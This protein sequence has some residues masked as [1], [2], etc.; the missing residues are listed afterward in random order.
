MRARRITAAFAAALTLMACG[1]GT[2]SSATPEVASAVPATTEAPGSTST[3]TP[4]STS[5]GS[6]PGSTEN[7]GSTS[8]A[9]DPTPRS[10][11]KPKK[12]SAA[13]ILIQYM[14]S[15]RAAG[16]VVRTREQA[17]SVAEKVLER[18]KSGDDFSRLA[19]EFS[20]EPGAAQRGGS[21]GRFGHGQMVRAFEDAAFALD[22]GQVSGI[23]ETPFGF[24]II[25]RTE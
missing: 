10:S 8:A 6:A 23:V 17:R 24:H 13:H 19:V 2:Q 18:A 11:V 20:D 1:G 7:P 3:S 12:I 9:S 15:D 21:L 16:S 14:G 22:V 25:K 5:S 4:A